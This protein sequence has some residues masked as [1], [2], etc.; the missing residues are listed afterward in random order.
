MVKKYL[1]STLIALLIIF[2]D[3]YSKLYLISYLKTQPGYLIEITSFFDIVYAWNYGASFG[4]LKGYYQYSNYAF[5]SL[6]SLILLLLIGLIIR[7]RSG[8][9]YISFSCIVGGALGNIIDRITHGA[10]FDFLY[11]HY[12]DYH[13]PV[14]NIAD[15][16]ISIGAALYIICY[17][18]SKE[19][20]DSES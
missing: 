19:R 17:Y 18:F 13:F 9:E 1:T 7:A 11:F 20:K 16:F 12:G 15:S 4:F 6:N 8:F 2:A 5:I 14:F 10:V 3:Q